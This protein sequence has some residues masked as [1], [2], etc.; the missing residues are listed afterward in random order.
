[1]GTLSE[2]H[3]AKL[4]INMKH[5]DLLAGVE[6]YRS[7]AASTVGDTLMQ[8]R[9]LQA[10]LVNLRA[11]V[12]S[13]SSRQKVKPQLEV[14]MMTLRNGAQR[15]SRA[16]AMARS[17]DAQSRKRMFYGAQVPELDAQSSTA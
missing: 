7:T 3:R 4:E 1:M 15:L 8:L 6:K 16:R 17:K 11:D 14:I 5:L 13:Q 10:D 2:E 12:K 9:E